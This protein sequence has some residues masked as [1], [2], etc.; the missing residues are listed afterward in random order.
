MRSKT[1]IVAVV[2]AAVFVAGVMAMHG[3][4]HRMLAKWMPAIHGR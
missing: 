1:L 4:G 2:L 3:K